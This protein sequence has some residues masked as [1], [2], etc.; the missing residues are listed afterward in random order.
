MKPVVCE[1]SESRP[2]EIYRTRGRDARFE[3]TAFWSCGTMSGFSTPHHG[4]NSTEY[5]RSR[6]PAM[7]HVVCYDP[8]ICGC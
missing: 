1:S 5:L 2:F 6:A 8:A 3:Q 7:C 4:P